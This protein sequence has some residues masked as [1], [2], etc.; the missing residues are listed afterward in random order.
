MNFE[1][2]YGEVGGMVIEELEKGF[3][4]QGEGGWER[5]GIVN[6]WSWDYF[7]VLGLDF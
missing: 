1:F 7:L 4:G 6:S 5:W 3:Y 2:E